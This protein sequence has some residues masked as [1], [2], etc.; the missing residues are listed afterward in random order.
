MNKEFARRINCKKKTFK[1]LYNLL[2]FDETFSIYNN[3]KVIYY[4]G[5]VR[6]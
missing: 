3:N 4:S 6:F 5:K 2:I 1:K